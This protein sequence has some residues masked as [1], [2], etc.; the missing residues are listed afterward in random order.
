MYFKV[1]IFYQKNSKSRLIIVRVF[2]CY[3]FLGTSRT[4][5]RQCIK[6][7]CILI[8][9]SLAGDPITEVLK[10][11]YKYLSFEHQTKYGKSKEFSE[12]NMK[13]HLVHV[14]QQS[15]YTDCGLYLLQYVESFFAVS[16]FT[17]GSLSFCY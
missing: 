3:F 10:N 6:Q 14:P 15:N 5:N 16:F 13:G 4:T 9:D 1:N 17:V 12:D 8:F 7:P 11:L 2:G